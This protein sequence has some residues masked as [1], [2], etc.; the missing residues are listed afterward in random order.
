M[1][2]DCQRYMQLKDLKPCVV[3][4]LREEGR[5]SSLDLDSGLEIELVETGS[6]HSEVVPGESVQAADN[7]RGP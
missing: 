2:S 1:D 6:C 3:A 7:Y 4:D 5:Q